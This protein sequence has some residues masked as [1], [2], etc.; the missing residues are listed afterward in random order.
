[1]ERK[2]FIVDDHPISRDGIVN[3]IERENDDLIVC[4]QAGDTSEALITIPRLKPDIV[5]TDINLPGP[6][7]L[8]LIKEILSNTPD[9]PFLVISMH[10]EEHYAERVLRAGARGYLTKQC[11]PSKIR[12]AI[13]TILKGEVYFS[14]SIASQLL[15]FYSKGNMSVSPLKRLS[16][17]ELEI[18]QL[19]GKGRTTSEI[20]EQLKI[21]PRTVDTHR[22]NIKQKLRLKGVNDLTRYA[23]RYVDTG[24]LSI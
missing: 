13:K 7:G 18:F 22:A 6:S 5:L 21:S 1:M 17:R 4:G 11:K 8:D 16:D 20:A 14:S 12:E 10:E 2:V 19:I 9:L 23:S 3:L 24:E 15:T